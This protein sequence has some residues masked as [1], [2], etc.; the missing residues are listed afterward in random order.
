MGGQ[1]VEWVRCAQKTQ[2]GTLGNPPGG[3]GLVAAL[4]AVDFLKLPQQ[5]TSSYLIS[6]EE[7]LVSGHR[8]HEP[9]ISPARG[10]WER[11]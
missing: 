2:E 1:A 6:S 11:P 10:G 9:A 8:S 3:L 7:K 4:E 5:E